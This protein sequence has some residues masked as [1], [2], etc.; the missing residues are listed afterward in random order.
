M[1]LT[2]T[3][4]ES[5][6]LHKEVWK[7]DY[8][9]FGWTFILPN[10]IE[11]TT[12]T[13]CNGEHVESNSLEGLDGWLYIDTKEDLKKF[14]NMEYTEVLEYLNDKHEDFDIDEFSGWM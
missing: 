8:N 4:I 14:I 12:L 13:I 2:L 7:P 11:L 10:G 5:F 1:K 9:D 3:I 6:N